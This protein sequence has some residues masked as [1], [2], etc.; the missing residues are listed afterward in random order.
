MPKKAIVN[1][2]LDC[3]HKTQMAGYCKWKCL[4]KDKQIPDGGIIPYWCPLEDT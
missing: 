1:N 2:C 3:P 4:M